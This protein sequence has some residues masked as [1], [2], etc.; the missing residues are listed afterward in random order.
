MAILASFAVV[1]TYSLQQNLSA[2]VL[3]RGPRGGEKE[4]EKEEEEGEEEEE[5]EEEEEG[6]EEEMR[7]MMHKSAIIEN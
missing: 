4:K 6:E 7:W 5:E 2:F 1:C 3:C